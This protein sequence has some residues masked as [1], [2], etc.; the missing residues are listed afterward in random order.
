VGTVG[1]RRW[2]R[3]A[4]SLRALDAERGRGTLVEVK[5]F[6][7]TG[8]Q[9]RGLWAVRRRWAWKYVTMA[10]ECPGVVEVVMPASI[11]LYAVRLRALAG[12]QQRAA[13]AAAGGD[14]ADVE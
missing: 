5:W 1:S 8:V 6:G 10:G 4:G 14:N 9:W 11:W 12:M 3:F 7:A 13:R 2:D